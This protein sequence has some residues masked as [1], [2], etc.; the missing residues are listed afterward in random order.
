MQNKS[1]SKAKKVKNDEFYT[2][3]SDIEKELSHYPNYFENATIFCNCDDPEE[4][5]FWK[6]FKLNFDEL[7]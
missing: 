3:L 4:S 2:Y 7:R 5:E 6:Y 1:L